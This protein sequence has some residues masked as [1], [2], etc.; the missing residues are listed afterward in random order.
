MGRSL[1][2]LKARSRAQVHGINGVPLRRVNQ[3]YAIATS[4]KVDISNVDVSAVNDAFFAREKAC[5]SR[6][7]QL[8]LMGIRKQWNVYLLDSL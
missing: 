2:V 4:S 7:K 8:C 1:K 3:R 5:K 6:V